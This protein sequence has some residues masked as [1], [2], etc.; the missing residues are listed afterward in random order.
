MDGIHA[1]PSRRH[2]LER[3]T[4]PEAKLG[5]VEEGVDEGV[6]G[7]GDVVNAPPLIE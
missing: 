6:G 3:R 4:V 7:S 2:V 1:L 5:L